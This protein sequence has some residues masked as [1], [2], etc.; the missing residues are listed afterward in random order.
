[1]R[2]FSLFL[3]SLVFCSI[4]QNAVCDVDSSSLLWPVPAKL[5]T[6]DSVVRALDSDNFHFNTDINSA[7]LDKAFQRYMGI[8]FQTP[9]AF[10]PDGAPEKVTETMPMLTVKVTSGDETLGP[11]VDESCKIS[12]R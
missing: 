3:L 5:S 8:L 6:T 4:F 2:Y 12:S 7:L 9:T 11:D 1:M 10:V